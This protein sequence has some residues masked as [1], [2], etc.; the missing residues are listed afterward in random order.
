MTSTNLTPLETAL[1][2]LLR[3]RDTPRTPGARRRSKGRGVPRRLSS[4]I[5]QR[6]LDLF[7]R[8]QALPYWYHD[9]RS[10]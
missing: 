9:R 8:G 10:G 4:S 1:R 6:E 5:V 7:R 2:R 3:D